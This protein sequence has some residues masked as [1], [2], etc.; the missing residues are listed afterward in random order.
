MGTILDRASF[1]RV[2][3]K[4]LAFF[5]ENKKRQLP[6]TNGV[7]KNIVAHTARLATHDGK[8]VRPYMAY[9]GYISSG[10][11]DEKKIL[12][13]LVGI[14]LFHVFALIHDDIIDGAQIRH[15]LPTVHA[16]IEK[17]L[18]SSPHAK[19]KGYWQALLAGDLAYTW[20]HEALLSNVPPHTGERVRRLFYA[21][22]EEVIMGQMIDVAITNRLA[23]SARAIE[24][25]N[26]LKTARYT[27]VH[28]LKIGSALSGK[29]ADL[30]P[31]FESFG[32]HIGTAFQVQDDLLD[33]IGD[34]KKTGKPVLGDVAEGQHTHFSQHVFTKGA[35]EEGAALARCFG[36][37]VTDQKNIRRLFET[38]GALAAG[39]KIIA[40][41]IKLAE[42]AITKA[43][44]DDTKKRVFFELVR[45]IEERVS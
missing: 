29:Q 18:S 30:D 33:I 35:K 16:H 17:L 26:L 5:L 8:R 39:R 37:K 36:K 6:T 27:F 15:G 7:V 21:M 3:D 28:P 9:L 34:P 32:A 20:A 22:I 19:Q 38:S 4:R 41:K 1:K 2:F 24:E 43:P 14:E 13:A 23:C 12:D 11:R 42:R 31:F 45:Q 10:G 44:L 25:K 40:R